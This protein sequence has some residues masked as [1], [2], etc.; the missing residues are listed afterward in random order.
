MGCCSAVVYP[1]TWDRRQGKTRAGGHLYI[2][3]VILVSTLRGPFRSIILWLW[4]VDPVRQLLTFRFTTVPISGMTSEHR[5]ME[6]GTVSVTG[7]EAQSSRQYCARYF[8]PH[9]CPYIILVYCFPLDT[10]SLGAVPPGPG[11]T[12]AGITC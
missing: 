9:E 11:N 7:S 5:G 12:V 4:K 10:V 1:S 8:S 3:Y 6:H 2:L